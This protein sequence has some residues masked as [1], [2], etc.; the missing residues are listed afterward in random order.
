MATNCYE[1]MHLTF[2]LKFWNMY[3][4]TRETHREHQSQQ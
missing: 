3:G 1:R 2:K 4:V